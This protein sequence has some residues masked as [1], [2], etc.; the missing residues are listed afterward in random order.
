MACDRIGYHVEK[1]VDPRSATEMGKLPDSPE[2]R[3]AYE[4]GFEDGSGGH[5]HYY[6][7]PRIAD[8]PPGV[9]VVQP[10]TTKGN[11]Q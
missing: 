3:I 2:A 7:Q 1:I 10:N 6:L 4:C 9:D 5:R 11:A 8:R